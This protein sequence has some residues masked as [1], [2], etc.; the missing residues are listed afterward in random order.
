MKIQLFT[1]TPHLL[2]P[3]VRKKMR[4]TL[5]ARR[6]HAR[7]A[8]EPE[9]ADDRV[10]GGSAQ[11]ARVEPSTRELHGGRLVWIEKPAAR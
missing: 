11:A 4:L 7:S 10:E 5:G 1:F 8:H 3:G 9:A 6:D 2:G